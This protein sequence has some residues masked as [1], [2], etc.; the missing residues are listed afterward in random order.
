[1]QFTIRWWPSERNTFVEHGELGSSNAINNLI[2]DTHD[3]TAVQRGIL[4]LRYGVPTIENPVVTVGPVDFPLT[5]DGLA[6]L[7]RQP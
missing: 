7:L 1:M 5:L 6:A 4:A 3:L 2:I